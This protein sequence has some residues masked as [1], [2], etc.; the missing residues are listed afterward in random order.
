MIACEEE[1]LEGPDACC[2][3]GHLAGWP[4]TNAVEIGARLVNGVRRARIGNEPAEETIEVNALPLRIV[5]VLFSLLW[6][7]INGFLHRAPL[8]NEQPEHHAYYHDELENEEDRPPAQTPD[9]GR[10]GADD[11][12]RNKTSDHSADSP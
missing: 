11:R 10:Y 3:R 4:P 8:A 1:L 6:E 7:V 2:L 12:G 9:R 5:R